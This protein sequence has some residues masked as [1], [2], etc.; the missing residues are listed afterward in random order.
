MINF[1]YKVVKFTLK[2][3]LYATHK[4]VC[5]FG[6][7]H[8][9]KNKPVLFLPNHQSALIDVLLIATDGSRK[10][11]FLTR[12]DVFGNPLLNF[13]FKFFRMIPIYRIRDGRK[14]LSKNESV[15]LNCATL[16]GKGEAIVMFPEANHSLKRRVRPLSKGFTRVLFKAKEMYSDVDIC[17]IPVGLNYQD[18]TKFSTSVA[19]Y[20]GAP[21]MLNDYY[22]KVELAKSAVLLKEKVSSSLKTLTTHIPK[23]H[24]YDAFIAHLELE[25]MS[26][27]FPK[28]VNERINEFIESDKAVMPKK[29]FE[30]NWLGVFR[31]IFKVLNLPVILFWQTLIKK[32]IP[33]PEFIGTFRFAVV[34][35]IFP[36]Y[37]TLLFSV[38]SLFFSVKLALAVLL[39][40]V[41]FNWLF[42]KY[43]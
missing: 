34:L 21:I 1:L 29:K 9:P 18:A 7:E 38:V 8:I 22:N 36:M 12:A 10:P 41:S 19:V 23:E 27:L 2:A 25:D 3:A 31:T 26:Y 24:D 11:Y 30:S 37:L 20:Y 40:I 33:E 43:S 32:R 6:L 35:L 42:V 15:F 16:L 39:L 28:V 5:V 13:V 14:S 4:K 17:I